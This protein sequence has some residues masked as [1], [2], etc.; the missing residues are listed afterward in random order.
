[1][2]VSPAALLLPDCA[3]PNCRSPGGVKEGEREGSGGELHTVQ[4]LLK[5]STIV[6]CSLLRPMYNTDSCLATQISIFGLIPQ[7]RFHYS[8]SQ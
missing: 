8:F 6:I 1:M 4:G 7:G 3:P 5:M 2:C